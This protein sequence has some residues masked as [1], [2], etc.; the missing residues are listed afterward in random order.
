MTWPG[1]PRGFEKL[2]HPVPHR[3]PGQYPYQQELGHQTAQEPAVIIHEGPH[4]GGEQHVHAD[5]EGGHNA[6]QA[7]FQPLLDPVENRE[8]PR[9]GQYAEE[10]DEGGHRRGDQEEHLRDEDEQGK[11]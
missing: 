2:D 9:T 6:V 7:G 1:A 3:L 8:N 5:E 4:L 11:E 10:E